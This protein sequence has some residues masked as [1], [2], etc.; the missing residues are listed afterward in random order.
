MHRPFHFH[1]PVVFLAFLLCAASATAAQRHVVVNG[2]RMTPQ[3]LGRLD[4]AQCTAIPDGY[5]WLDPR[6]GAWG[7][8]GNPVRQG[9]LGDGC[10]ARHGSLSERRRLFRP[11]ELSGVEVI[12]R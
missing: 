11:G 7:Y 12:G 10:G 1:R 4:A 5:Y 6:T 3:Q 9:W 8:A 2:Q